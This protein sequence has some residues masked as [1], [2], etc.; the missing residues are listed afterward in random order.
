[1]LQKIPK[2][3]LLVI[4]GG[5]DLTYGTNVT[6]SNDGS[7][8]SFAIL[9]ELIPKKKFKGK[10]HIEIITTAS[11]EPQEVSK[12]Y[13]KAFKKIGFSKVGFIYVGN[14]LESHNPK[15]IKRIKNAHAVLFSGGYQ[16]K[17]STILGDTDVLDAVRQRYLNDSSFIVAGSSAGAMALPE[18]MIVDSERNEAILNKNLKISSAFGF[19]DKCIVDTHF[20]QR[21]RFGRL[22]QAV[23]M[24]PGFLG[25]GIGEDTALLIRDG[26]HAEC[27]GSGIVIIIDGRDVGHTNIAYAEENEALCIENLKVNILSN[28]NGFLLR[29]RKFIPSKKDIKRELTIEKKKKKTVPT[30]DHKKNKS[31]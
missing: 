21:G 11:S 28:G 19:I 17:L 16:F 5:Q 24:N 15:F 3:K 26:N 13:S 2:G 25:I 8:Q 20:V 31:K 12:T 7:L 14:D 30:K 6:N 29:E 27:K 18:I 22:T 10:G 4:G 9:K 1:M 23:V